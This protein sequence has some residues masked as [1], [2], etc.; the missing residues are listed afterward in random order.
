MSAA[1]DQEKAKQDCR[2]YIGRFLIGQARCVGLGEPDLPPE[3]TIHL[4][5]EDMIEAF[6]ARH[7]ELIRHRQAFSKVLVELP[8]FPVNAGRWR[9]EILRCP[10]SPDRY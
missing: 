7:P 10:S 6:L 8:E 5:R 2:H 1:W 9:K 3:P 4:R